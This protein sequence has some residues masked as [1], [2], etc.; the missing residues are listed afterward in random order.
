MWH[1]PDLCMVVY[2]RTDTGPLIIWVRLPS[3]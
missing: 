2:K 3:G 1:A